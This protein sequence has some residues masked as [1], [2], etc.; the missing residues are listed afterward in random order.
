MSLCRAVADDVRLPRRVQSWVDQEEL[1]G[2][3]VVP[4]DGGAVPRRCRVSVGGVLVE[5][6]S[7][8]AQYGQPGGEMTR[9]L[10]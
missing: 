10:A 4:E 5:E 3:P 2:R 9:R 8:A 1:S 7:S 6:R